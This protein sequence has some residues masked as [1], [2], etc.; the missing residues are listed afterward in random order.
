MIPLVDLDKQY[1]SIKKDIDTAISNVIT[2]KSFIQGPFASSFE[3]EFSQVHRTKNVICTANGTMAITVA[4]EAAGIGRGDEVIT[5]PHTFIATVEAIL[6]VGAKP[7]F[8]D[9]DPHTYNLNPSLIE[10]AI[11]KNT[12]AILPVHIYGNPADMKSICKIA[13][14]HHLI[15][16]EDCAQA[17]LATIGNKFVGNFGQAGTFSFYPGKN[18]GAYGDAGAVITPHQRLASK[19]RMLI[20]HGRKDKY[21]HQIVGHNYR[22]DGLQAAILSAKLRHL[23]DWTTLRQQK[24]DLYRRFLQGNHKIILPQSYPRARHVYHLFVIQVPH[25]NQLLDF[26]KGEGIA[27]GI[28][29]PIP[30]HLQPALKHLGYHHGD[31]PVC[32][33]ISRHIISLPLYPEITPS[34]IKTIC[35][36][37]NKFLS[38]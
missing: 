13:K 11:T 19:I 33:K 38:K 28:H 34:E 17:H 7:V 10:S 5:T 9:I 21:T 8:I 23:Q 24:A 32:E 14:K 35:Q 4:L 36:K 16:I 18:L 6:E 37:I 30:L 27:A 31:F 2:S 1:Q 22:I 12:K 15:V 25:R 3:H 26:L 29:Y 20:D